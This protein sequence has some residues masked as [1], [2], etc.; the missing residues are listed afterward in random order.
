G[1]AGD[2]GT[3]A[4][5]RGHRSTGGRAVGR[6][7]VEG[8]RAA[9]VGARPRAHTSVGRS[10]A[11]GQLMSRG[12]AAAALVVAAVAVLALGLYATVVKLGDSYVGLGGHGTYETDRYA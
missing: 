6:R 12:I 10:Q 11:G 9:A 4:P 7:A 2:L 8:G 1:A 3:G 5:R